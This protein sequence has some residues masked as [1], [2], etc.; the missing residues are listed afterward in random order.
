MDLLDALTYEFQSGEALAADLGVS[1][2][3]VS[4]AAKVLIDDGYPV[5]VERSR[6]YKL[7]WGTPSPRMLA[8]L[9]VRAVTR[10]YRYLGT[11][12]S[13][14]D[15]LRRWAEEGAPGGAVV[16][17]ERQ[18]HGRGRH[19]RI[20]ES[21]PGIS[22]TFSVLLRPSTPV[23][24]LPLISLAAGVA[25]AEAISPGRGGLKWPNDL[26]GPGGG[27]LAGILVEARTS[28]EETTYVLVGIGV[29]VEPPA[30]PDG[31]VLNTV[32]GRNAQHRAYVLDRILEELEAAF[33]LLAEPTAVVRA[34]KEHSNMMGTRVR[35]E[36]PAGTISG[37]ARDIDPTGAL[38][39]ATPD[40][41]EV[42]HAG[43]VTLVR[44]EGTD[45]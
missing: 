40:G 9:N 20:W 45:G 34:W 37:H 14:Q 38:I 3:A 5:D 17:A 7:H 22:L 26:L 35:V 11:L 27:K 1:R 2:A 39:V 36:T 23:A 32:P 33:A 31:A 8:T 16:V 13:T 30:P 41:D 18:Q 24:Q 29:N 42:I 4:K 19:G 28:G 44:E 12:D 10:P 43:D 21:H 6:G 25:I 15:E